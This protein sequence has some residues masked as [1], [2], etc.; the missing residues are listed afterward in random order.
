MNSSGAPVAE[1][2]RY[3][4]CCT[5]TCVWVLHNRGTPRPHPYAAVTVASGA[6]QPTPRASP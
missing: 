1:P 4:L 3:G 5:M 6:R 2:I